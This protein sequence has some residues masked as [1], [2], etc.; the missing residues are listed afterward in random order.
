MAKKVSWS[1]TIDDDRQVDLVTDSQEKGEYTMKNIKNEATEVVITNNIIDV[2]NDVIDAEDY[3][4]P[5]V[6]ER[7]EQGAVMSLNGM[8]NCSIE[9]GHHLMA[10][11]DNLPHGE[12]GKSL[13]IVGIDHRKAN[14]LMAITAKIGN[15]NSTLTSNLGIEKS[16]ALS[17]LPKETLD[18]LFDGGDIDGMSL[19]DVKT[20]PV[21]ELEKRI[22]EATDSLKKENESIKKELTEKDAIHSK[23]LDTREEQIRRLEVEPD[24]EAIAAIKLQVE[25]EFEAELKKARQE[26]ADEQEIRAE[27]LANRDR[28][29]AELNEI[30]NQEGKTE[31]AIAEAKT[32]LEKE[33][34]A[35]FLVAETEFKRKETALNELLAS[36]EELIKQK[37]IAFQ[38]QTLVA[39]A[40]VK[41]VLPMIEKLRPMASQFLFAIKE[42]YT[43]L[44]DAK[45]LSKL[46][47]ERLF[48]IA[49]SEA[50]S[51]TNKL[52][53]SLNWIL[54]ISHDI[55]EE[56]GA[57]YMEKLEN[58]E[59]VDE[60]FG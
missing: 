48:R 50:T 43:Q 37:T 7:H 5:F 26:V 33:F 24:E 22:K 18:E 46:A 13:Q 60:V 3:T 17:R 57:E 1:E 59:F 6:R 23:L 39:E 52:N 29:I 40:E 2:D 45:H 58:G 31:Q 54:Y 25:A 44:N 51:L 16:Y 28:K 27:M 11:K 36:K 8:V 9:A 10:L 38:D 12:F 32:N 35:K 19:E 20:I 41:A 30:V 53:E 14:K 42:M 56:F 4:P 49:V 15:S 34:E 47:R 55:I 21:R